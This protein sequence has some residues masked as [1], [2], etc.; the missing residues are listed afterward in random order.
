MKRNNRPDTGIEEKDG[1]DHL[2]VVA[3]STDCTGLIPSAPQTDD[4][5]ESYT[6]LYHIPGPEEKENKE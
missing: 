4:E 2:N 3:S 5:I 1:L 6:H